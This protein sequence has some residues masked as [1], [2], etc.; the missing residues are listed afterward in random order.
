[1]AKSRSHKLALVVAALVLPAALAGCG[2]SNSTS[3]AA[4]VAKGIYTTASDCAD[5]G[6]LTY[7]QCSDLIYAAVEKHEADAPTY[8][9]L[10]F[11]EAKEGEGKCEFTANDKIRPKLLAFLVTASQPPHAI[12]LYATPKGEPGFRDLGGA[13]YLHTNEELVFSEH[14]VTVFERNNPK[15]M[16]RF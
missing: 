12:P 15:R 1:M 6:K 7:E 14:A 5:S 13:T 4:K 9:E 11:C 8:T 16:R 3:P 10:R 2:G